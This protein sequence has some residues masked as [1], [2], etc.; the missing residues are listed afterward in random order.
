MGFS[1]FIVILG[2]TLM[3]MKLGT[4]T[5]TLIDSKLRGKLNQKQVETE[6]LPK[7]LFR[8]NLN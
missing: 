4:F 8:E 1:F 5:L 7:K 6:F 3:E 2:K